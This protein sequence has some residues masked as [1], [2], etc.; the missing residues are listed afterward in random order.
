MKSEFS[1]G[2]AFGLVEHV[3]S[4][5]AFVAGLLAIV[6]VSILS[7]TN[8][9]CSVSAN[10]L[11]RDEESISTC[12]HP[13]FLRFENGQFFLKV[14]L[15]SFGSSLHVLYILHISIIKI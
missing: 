8:L 13:L 4:Q 7:L 11:F 1:E 15:L 14:V 3:I 6:S 5:V 12:R 9:L 2:F 10:S